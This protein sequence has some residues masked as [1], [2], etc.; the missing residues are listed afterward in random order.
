MRKW[1]EDKTRKMAFQS[2]EIK[3]KGMTASIPSYETVWA[4]AN[5]PCGWRSS[6]IKKRNRGPKRLHTTILSY[7]DSISSSPSITPNQIA[8]QS[9]NH[10]KFHIIFACILPTNPWKSINSIWELVT[11]ATHQI[12][13]NRPDWLKMAC[14]SGPGGNQLSRLIYLQYLSPLPCLNW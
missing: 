5:H 7:I 14:M 12:S 10:I 4:S 1:K 6:F 9:E 13:A 3:N 8:R 2:L 11:G